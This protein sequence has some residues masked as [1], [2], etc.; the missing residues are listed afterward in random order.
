MAKLT[1]EE[2]NELGLRAEAMPRH[3]AMIMD[4]N[5][6][7]AKKNGF[8]RAMGHRAGVTRLR[9]LVRFSSDSGIK[10]LTLY[11]FSTENWK[12]PDDE[13]GVLFSLLIEFFNKEIDE[14]H[15]NN[16]CIRSIGELDAFPL[17]VREAV[18]NAEQR[19]KNNGGLMLN[20]ALNYGSQAEILRAAGAL[21]KRAI[22]TGEL[23][24]KDDFEQ[25]LYTCGLPELD[26]L[27]RTSGELR[28]SN[29]LLYQAAYAELY[30]TDVFWPD[31]TKEE[32]IKAIKEYQRRSRRYGGL[33]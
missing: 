15:R 18:K 6:R 22:E 5:G 11:A 1:I 27:I 30:F 8:L 12:R 2:L 32:Y 23:P 28:L 25:E 21:C 19:T 16:V 20:I 9:E 13:L 4:G 29:Y 31:F 26:L 17:K 33:E 14:L 24:T 7:W 3:V 10:A